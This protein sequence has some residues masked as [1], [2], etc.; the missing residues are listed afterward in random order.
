MK[1]IKTYEEREVK[2]LKYLAREISKILSLFFGEEIEVN[3]TEGSIFGPPG[4]IDKRPDIE[5]HDLDFVDLE[6]KQIFCEEIERITK[7]KAG[8]YIT[9]VHLTRDEANELLRQL[10]SD[11]FQFLIDVKKY[12]L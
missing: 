9:A 5:I 3:S 4:V 1:Y 8:T 2:N 6:R 11:K 12:N 10:R 7:T